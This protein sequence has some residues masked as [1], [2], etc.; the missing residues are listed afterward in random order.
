MFL[1]S[2][3]LLIDPMQGACGKPNIE[4]FAFIGESSYSIPGTSY[5]ISKSNALMMYNCDENSSCGCDIR[6]EFEGV[7]EL[8]SYFNCPSRYCC[9][10]VKERSL[11]RLM[12]NCTSFVS[13]AIDDSDILDV[14]RSSRGLR[15]QVQY[16]LQLE[17]WIPGR[18]CTC[19]SNADCI[20]R[21]DDDGDRGDHDDRGDGDRGDRGDRRDG[22][23]GDRG[24]R[25]DRRDGA[26]YHHTCR[27]RDG[28]SGDGFALGSGCNADGAFPSCFL[29]F[30]IAATL[31]P[32]P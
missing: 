18:S 22:D 16:G 13:W 5:F 11:L 28:F 27:C 10:L 21:I 1:S 15:I 17:A 2:Q 26:R 4:Y 12:K 19:S 25:G 29:L 14:A 3:T 9:G 6:P 32:K 31:N 8:E 20:F 7:A 24:D 23:L 30:P